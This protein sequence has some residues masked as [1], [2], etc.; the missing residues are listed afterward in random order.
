MAMKLTKVKRKGAH[1]PPYHTSSHQR[2]L[3]KARRLKILNKKEKP[4][5]LKS[6]DTLTENMIPTPTCS[7][8]LPEK[9]ESRVSVRVNGIRG[10]ILYFQDL[11]ILLMFRTF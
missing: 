6:E 9:D 2:A 4:L 10:L 1:P 7:K 8:A 3:L 5:P 11:F